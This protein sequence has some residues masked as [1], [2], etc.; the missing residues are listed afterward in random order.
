MLDRVRQSLALRLAIQYALVFAFGAALLFGVLYWLLAEAFDA[1]E[2]TILERQ[3]ATIAV[4]YQ[5]AGA[6]A[7][8]ALP[9]TTMFVRLIA[10]NNSATF[11]KVPPDWIETQVQQLPIPGWTQQIRT[12]RVPQ[13]A[14]RDYTIASS[15]L[16]NGWLLQAGRLLDSR[17][18]LLAPLRRAF[19][20]RSN[21]ASPVPLLLAHVMDVMGFATWQ[22]ALATPAVRLH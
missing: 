10:P 14:D 7:L 18:V 5:S 4:A 3:A 21:A 17:A 16:P 15:P 19:A 9:D 11:V 12:V 2:R 6:A 20:L 22:P 8:N 13:N 1:R